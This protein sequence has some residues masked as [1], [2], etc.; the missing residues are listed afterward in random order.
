MTDSYLKVKETTEQWCNQLLDEG[1]YT[2]NQY[3]KCLSNFVDLGQGDLPPE[4]TPPKEGNEHAYSLYD[5]REAHTTTKMLDG[6]TITLSSPNNYYLAS[7][8]DGNISIVKETNEG[9]ADSIEWKIHHIKGHQYAFKSLSSNKY[10]GVDTKGEFEASR[11]A[12][13]SQSMWLVQLRGNFATI[14]SVLFDNKRITIEGTKIILSSGHRDGQN[15]VITN[16]KQKDTRTH[17]LI[18]NKALI[19]QKNTL[20]QEIAKLQSNII[21]GEIEIDVLNRMPDATKREYEK[22]NEIVAKNAIA[23]NEDYLKKARLIRTSAGE[24]VRSRGYVD[25]EDCADDT[26]N[27]CKIEMDVQLGVKNGKTFMGKC[28]DTGKKRETQPKTWGWGNWGKTTS[29]SIYKICKSKTKCLEAVGENEGDLEYINKYSDLSNKDLKKYNYTDM[30]PYDMADREHITSGI[31]VARDMKQEEFGNVINNLQINMENDTVQYNNLMKSYDTFKQE[32]IEEFRRKE[33]SIRQNDIKI[34]RQKNIL[35]QTGQDIDL[36]EDK[37][38]DLTRKEGISDVNATKI[39]SEISS[40]KRT[41]LAFQVLMVIS[42]IIVGI[43][44]KKM[45]F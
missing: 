2:Q 1:I 35:E 19:E 7:N 41:Y 17:E 26:Q 16:L 44:V 15:W 28:V 11:E 9:E 27:L 31:N 5:R 20:L 39:E 18:E 12:P 40:L 43:L 3:E 24:C 38:E 34:S 13:S 37:V 23:I 30:V 21:Q 6:D 14:S 36:T 10:L 45:V 29:N 22:I 42:M 32:L 4:Y 33:E 8:F 25:K